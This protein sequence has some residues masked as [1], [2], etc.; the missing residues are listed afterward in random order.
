MLAIH[1]ILPIPSRVLLSLRNFSTLPSAASFTTSTTTATSSSSAAGTPSTTLSTSATSVASPRW[2]HVDATGKV[3][4]RLAS[5]LAYIL[6][7]KHKPTYDRAIMNGDIVV[8]SNVEK[9]MFTGN[10]MKDKEYIHH[11]LHPGGLKRIPLPQVPF[12]P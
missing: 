7:G 4:G 3:V 8:V 1:R 10:K 2:W 9:I 11:T 5:H 12:P 6:Q